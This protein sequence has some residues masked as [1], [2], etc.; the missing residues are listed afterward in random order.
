MVCEIWTRARTT[1]RRQATIDSRIEHLDDDW[2]EAEP[3]GD[4]PADLVTTLLQD[5][6]RAKVITLSRPSSS[7]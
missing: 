1:L 2:D 5:A 6:V 4:D 3:T 7:R